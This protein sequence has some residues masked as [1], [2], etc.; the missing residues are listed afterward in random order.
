MKLDV[1]QCGN[2]RLVGFKI[3]TSHTTAGIDIPALWSKLHEARRT[4]RIPVGAGSK[5]YAVYHHYKHQNQSHY[6]Y[7][8]GFC[9]E[10]P[11]ISIL[12]DTELEMVYV[13]RSRYAVFKAHGPFPDRMLS[14]WDWIWKHPSMQNDL[15]HA[16]EVYPEH[17]DLLADTDLEL[18]VNLEN[19]AAPIDETTLAE[20]SEI[21]HGYRTA[22][23]GLALREKQLM[24]A[25]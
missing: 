17:H 8:V 11:T 22:T 3:T 6:T 15:R 14:I 4:G 2:L 18:W 12:L 16:V 1:K 5:P 10:Q 21:A 24:Q 7:F 20:L 23:S 19:Y 25:A 13:P 9:M